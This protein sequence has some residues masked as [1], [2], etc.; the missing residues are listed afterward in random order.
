MHDWKSKIQVLSTAVASLAAIT[1]VLGFASLA[2]AAK[3]GP[4]RKIVIFDKSFVNEN[5]QKGLLRAF[6][7][8]EEG[9]KLG[10]I[11]GMA[12]R[13]PEKAIEALSKNEKVILVEDDIKVQATK[14]PYWAGGGNG[15]GT[16]EPAQVLPWGVDRIDAE[17][18]WPLKGIGVKVAVIDTGIDKKHPDLAV[19]EGINFISYSLV[20]GPNPAK[21][22]D[23]NGHGTHVAGTIAA[24]DNSKGVVGVAPDVSLYAVKVLDRNGTGFVSDVIAGIEWAVNNGMHLANMSLSSNVGNTSLYYA[25]NAAR[26]AGLIIVAAAGNDGFAVDYPAAYSSVIAVAA[27][28]SNDNVPHFSSRGI[29]IDVA[30][31]GVSIFSTDAGGGYATLYGTSMAAP[32]VTGA[33]ALLISDDLLSGGMGNFDFYMNELCSTADDLGTAGFDSLTGCGLVDAAQLATGIEV[34][35]D[36]P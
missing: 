7:A 10:I 30:A 35:N 29:Q 26:D 8:E 22:N 4:V 17:W 3:G 27:V 11:N 31:P 18:A 33:L 14:K 2:A 1:M 6:G 36:L 15:A 28:D 34:G 23:D 13:L 12:V 24:L 19:E 20:K 16:P 9:L 21:W 32:H 25:C 5:A